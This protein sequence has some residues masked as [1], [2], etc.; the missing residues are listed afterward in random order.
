[1]K[2]K[3]FKLSSFQL[4][5]FGFLA[6]IFLGTCLLML[7]FASTDEGCAS[8]ADSL[9]T[10][11]S[12]VCV[13][14]LIVQDTATYW[15]AFGQAVILVLIQIGGL[16]VITMAL[17]LSLITGKKIGLLQRN[18]MKESISAPNV[19]GI[20]RMTGFILKTTAVIEITGAL[21]MMPVFCSELGV[22]GIWY[23][24]FHSVS[25]F[26]NAGFDLMGYKEKF[27]SVTSFYD[28]S[29]INI[30]LMLLIVVGGIGF[31]VW[32]DVKTQGIHFKRYRLQ[33]KL[34]FTVTAVLILIPSLYYFFF[35]FTPE[36]WTELTLKDRVLVSLFQAIT[37]RTAGFNTVDLSKMSG[38]SQALMIV[39]MLIGGS[40][41]STAGGLKVTT[42]AVL[43]CSLVSVLKR[44]ESTEAF[45]R[46]IP[47][48]RVKYAGVLLVMYITLFF[49]SGMIISQVDAL[50]ISSALFET[51][52]AVGT[53]GLTLGITTQLSLISRAILVV[54]MFIGRV[55]GITVIY[56]TLSVIKNQISQLPQENLTV[57]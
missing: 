53:V 24:I 16:G 11:T 54:L 19:G 31:T 2:K 39:L 37:P 47:N 56:A 30:V 12:A 10:A 15:T 28:N 22:K 57:G 45:G 13:T 14:G 48:D 27:S 51:S 5:S 21:I 41:G 50:P 42:V 38:A 46:R 4:I 40:S 49:V 29:V 17:L 23:S 44:R 6:V 43:F 1:M 52:S 55:G 32:N 18:T 25:C 33:S 3:R 26:C 34:V 20:V 9:F 35:E 7:P 36:R 8:F